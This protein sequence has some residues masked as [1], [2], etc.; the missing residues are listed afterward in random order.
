MFVIRP[1][2]ATCAGLV[3]IFMVLPSSIWQGP[4]ADQTVVTPLP[5]E[6]KLNASRSGERL[7]APADEPQQSHRYRST[8]SDR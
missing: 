3:G 4:D 2:R 8:A 1:G 6:R 5:I 7:R